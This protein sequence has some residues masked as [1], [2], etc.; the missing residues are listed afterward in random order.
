[1]SFLLIDINK[2]DKNGY[3]A[4]HF[5]CQYGHREIVELLIK[6]GIDMS[7][8]DNYLDND[9]LDLASKNGHNEIA[10]LLI[11]NRH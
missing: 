1:M 7:E 6:N 10:K 2:K 3:N 11:R 8:T 4:L 5:A 9:A